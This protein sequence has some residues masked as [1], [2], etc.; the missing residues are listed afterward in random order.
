V[1]TPG[2]S[3]A[4]SPR[5]RLEQGKQ[6][7][8]QA[9]ER[10]A[11]VR[12]AVE[13]ARRDRAASGSV[14]A[15]AL[16][17]RIFLW[18]LPFALLA[19]AV[20]GFLGAGSDALARL[21]GW[22]LPDPALREQLARAA[23]QAEQGRYVTASVGVALLVVATVGLGRAMDGVITG[24]WGLSRPGK[25]GRLRRATR[26]SG[27]LVGIAATHV[28]ALAVRGGPVADV[29]AAAATF[30]AFVLLARAM[31]GAHGSGHGAGTAWG[32]VLVAT[33]L[34]AMR[35]IGFYYLPHKLERS[36]ELYGTLGV[37]AALLLWLTILAR[38]IVLGHVL[39]AW[40]EAQTST[41]PPALTRTRDVA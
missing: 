25:G 41:G 27:A 9:E 12:L 28:A 14:L 5:R 19:T 4:R 40:H 15:A 6:R 38:L 3:S 29:I 31:L 30:G 10:H 24:V 21:S 17:A 39:N 37:A 34:E 32:A 18:A 23:A 8:S 16:A 36:S 7:L 1:A 33:G 13:L 2:T 20:L 22:L 11:T 35:L 26:Y